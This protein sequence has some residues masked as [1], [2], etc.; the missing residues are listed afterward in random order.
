MFRKKPG[1]DK[2]EAE[3]LVRLAPLFGVR[4]GIY[5]TAL[6]GLVLLIILFFILIYPGLTNPGSLFIVSSEPSGAA[7]RVDGVTRGAA[8]CEIFVP[9][10]NRVIEVV[11]PGF[12]SLRMERDVP[13]RIFASVF[14]PRKEYI[15]GKLPDDSPGAALTL[16]AADYAEWSF[17]GEPT[18]AFQIP[19][20]LSEGAYRAG[21][22]GTDPGFRKNFNDILRGALRFASTRAALR[23]LLRAK[24]LV[25]NGGLSPSPLTL[26]CSAE[27][28]LTYLAET[29]GSA[30]W[31]GALLPPESGLSVDSPWYQRDQEE[32]RVL[33]P[34]AAIPAEDLSGNTRELGPLRFREFPGGS[35]VLGTPFPRSVEVGGF[36]I[37]ETEVSAEAWDAFLRDA[38]EWRRENTGDLTEKG[39]VTS[40]YLLPPDNPSYPSPTVPAVSWYAA[41]AYCQWL[42]RLLPPS[43]AAWEVRLPTEVEWEYAARLTGAAGLP[44]EMTGGLWE[45]CEDPFAPLSFFPAE[46]EIIRD[47]GSPERPV[48]GGSWVSAPGSINAGTRAS[49]PPTSCSPFVSFRPILALREAP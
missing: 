28:I 36:W 32:G 23:D 2:T 20:S 9:R 4:P 33:G 29:P 39:L 17:A 26:L 47:I 45:W 1:P 6:Y 16:G 19:L 34:P 5:L 14:F 8:P 21:P 44:L 3:D 12:Q 37:A 41:R 40:D 31:L 25:D 30:A 18:A 48:K 24:F 49:L 42:T 43:L 15:T 38:P 13:G 46:G 35:L 22:A 11:L 10:G 7:V 27:E